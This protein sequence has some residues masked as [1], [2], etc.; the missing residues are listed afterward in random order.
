M[1]KRAV[2][3]EGL[4]FACST[5]LKTLCKYP[6]YFSPARSDSERAMRMRV[7]QR[8]TKELKRCSQDVSGKLL[9]NH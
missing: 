9:G 5:W 2:K 1:G 7:R 3:G 6:I 4:V 8:R